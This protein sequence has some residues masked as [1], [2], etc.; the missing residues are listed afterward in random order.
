MTID[1][2]TAAPRVPAGVADP[3]VVLEAHPMVREG[4]LRRVNLAL[5]NSIVVYAGASVHDATD[6]ALRR[7]CAC[8]VVDLEISPNVSPVDV[9]AQ[10]TQHGIQVLAFT[11]T[12]TEAMIESAIAAGAQGVIGKF[13]DPIEMDSAIDAVASGKTWFPCPTEVHD[14]AKEAS[15]CLSDRERCALTLYVSGL[16]QDSV[17]RRMGIA[18]S[19]VKHYL[20]RARRKFNDA[21]HPA[22]TKLE[23]FELARKQGLLP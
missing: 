13:I 10:F 1:E 14:V 3:V 5:P 6:A 11:Q 20:D 8:A 18:S 2:L 19:T 4:L 16:T 17:A 9:I 15:V 12:P 21:G 7:G 23:L 22:R